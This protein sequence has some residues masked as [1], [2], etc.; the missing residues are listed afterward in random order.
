[1][2]PKVLAFAGSTREDSSNKKAVKIAAAGAK[3]AGA[4]VEFIDIRDYPVPGYDAELEDKSGLPDNAKKLKQ[5]MIVSDGL[6]V[7]TPEYNGSTSGVLK[8]LLDWASRKE[9]GDKPGVTIFNHKV[10]IIMSA[11]TSWRGGILG[12]RHLRDIFMHEGCLVL[13]ISQHVSNSREAFNADGS[14]IDSE[15]QVAVMDLGKTLVEF[16]QK[17]HT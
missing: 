10:A 11:S 1:M 15:R 3:Q 12:Q 5:K 17:L 16:L 6:L 4:E 13:P 9:Q 7:S 8:N 14:L 2:K